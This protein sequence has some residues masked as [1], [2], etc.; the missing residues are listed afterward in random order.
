MGIASVSEEKT[1]CTAI[2]QNHLADGP[3]VS[4]PAY[5]RSER[6]AVSGTPN[7]FSDVIDL[8]SYTRELLLVG[9]MSVD[10]A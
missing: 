5:A 3:E 2:P 4:E 1:F 8:T 6:M 10:T 7:I 9:G